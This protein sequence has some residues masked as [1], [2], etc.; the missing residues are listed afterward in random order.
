MT[1]NAE[2][3]K[4]FIKD[5]IETSK[6]FVSN[7]EWDQIHQY[8]DNAGRYS[9]PRFQKAVKGDSALMVAVRLRSFMAAKY[10]LLQG[11][12][13]AI[14]NVEGETIAGVLAAKQKEI[15]EERNHIRFLRVQAKS[16]RQMALSHDDKLALLSEPQVYDQLEKNYEL[17][18][19]IS[20]LMEVRITNCRLLK[21]KQKRLI[22]EGKNLTPEELKEVS[23]E[24]SATSSKK[25]VDALAKEVKNVVV[26]WEG[27]KLA[28]ERALAV[29]KQ[30]Q[31]DKKEEK[32]RYWRTTMFKSATKIQAAWRGLWT[33]ELFRLFCLHRAC[34]FVQSKTRGFLCRTQLRRADLRRLTVMLQS[35]GRGYIGRKRVARKQGR[36]YPATA[37]IMAVRQKSIK[38]VGGE[39]EPHLSAA[40]FIRDMFKEAD[41]PKMT[42][43]AVKPK[44]QWAMLRFMG[45]KKAL[46]EIKEDCLKHRKDGEKLGKL[47]VLCCEH[48]TSDSTFTSPE[49]RDTFL[50]WGIMLMEKALGFNMGLDAIVH[51]F[52]RKRGDA[53][54][55][56]WN[57]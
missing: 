54:L 49:Q 5:R 10:L 27:S 34:V 36:V 14:T 29:Q 18:L 35:V 57:R 8:I 22:V 20:R 7:N 31:V 40:D 53:M 44:G 50:R 1:E 11:V 32:V 19:D 21:M 42:N 39:E 16:V 24:E 55:E 4:K 26:E 2:V 6:I 28:K 12:D 46:Q 47:A 23:L 41:K 3:L 17:C 43:V 56:A 30:A 45:Q 37:L 15:L 48:G 33:R 25:I 38:G 13:S 9:D 52:E 51:Q